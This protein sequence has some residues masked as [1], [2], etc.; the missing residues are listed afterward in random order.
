MDLKE[1]S[2]IYNRIG[3]LKRWHISTGMMEIDSMY[4]GQLFF[5][6]YIMN[7]PGCTQKDLADRFALSK[8]AVTKSVKKMIKNGLITRE[9]NREDERKYE[10]YATETGQHLAAKCRS[11]F[12][13][14]DNLFYRG[15]SEE[16]IE[17]FA[18]FLHRIMDNL[19][20]DYSRNK[21]IRDLVM[22]SEKR[23]EAKK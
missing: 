18:G 12:E 19:E 11:I 21:T 22:E 8:A 23:E 7:H 9:V 16:E 14:V 13:G 15:F 2:Y 3:Q 10:L 5:V 20:T 4:F 1:L 17:T 6:E